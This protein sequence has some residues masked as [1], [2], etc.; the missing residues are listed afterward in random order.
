MGDASSCVA[1]HRFFFSPNCLPTQ[2]SYTLL[3]DAYEDNTQKTNT[4]LNMIPRIS[5]S[6]ECA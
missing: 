1:V 5:T 6:R 4:D 3:A 2:L